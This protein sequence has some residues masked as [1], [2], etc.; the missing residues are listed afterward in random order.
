MYGLSAFL[1]RCLDELG[2][3]ERKLVVHD[4]GAL[5]LIGAQRRP[6]LVER[7]VVI[8]AVPLLPGYRWHWIAADLAPPAARRD[9]QRDHHPLAACDCCCARRAATAADARRSSST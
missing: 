5:A 9:L 2:V 7:L 8:N 3:G 6:E 1:E 4:W